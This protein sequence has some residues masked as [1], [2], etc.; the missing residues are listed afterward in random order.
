[1]VG[2]AVGALAGKRVSERGATRLSGR[3]PGRDRVFL[4]RP[5]QRTA[6][7]WSRRAILDHSHALIPLEQLHQNSPDPRSRESQERQGPT[8]TLPDPRT[9]DCE[10]GARVQP[11]SAASITK[12]FAEVFATREATEGGP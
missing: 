1:M 5:C 4:W 8:I 9:A 2:P 10:S 11:C 3:W 7:L 6:Q 12:Y